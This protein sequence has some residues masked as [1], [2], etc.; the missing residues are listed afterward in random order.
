MAYEQTDAIRLLAI[1]AVT[2]TDVAG[3][4]VLPISC[5]QVIVFNNSG[6]SI[7]LRTDPNNANSQVTI[8]SG[9]QFEIGSSGGSGPRSFLFPQGSGNPPCSL[10][11]SSGTVN[12]LIESLQ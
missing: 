5:N 6:V 7:F 9:Q 1:N 8:A 12:V 2:W 11:S 3:V 4:A 10:L